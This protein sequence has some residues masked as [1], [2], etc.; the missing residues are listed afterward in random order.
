MR[1]HKLA[2]AGSGIVQMLI[3]VSVLALGG[4]A[5]IRLLTGA[6][7]ARAECA[8]RQIASLDG[9]AVRCGEGLD[10]APPPAPPGRTDSPPP[11]RASVAS[12]AR[13]READPARPRP[14]RAPVASPTDDRE[15]DPPGPPPA[16]APVAFL[17]GGREDDPE[18]G[19]GGGSGNASDFDAGDLINP[20]DV[21][22]PQPRDNCLVNG[23]IGPVVVG[24]PIVQPEL[25]PGGGP[26]V[27]CGEQ[28]PPEPEA[29]IPLIPELE[30]R[31]RA[32][33]PPAR[34]T[35]RVN[36]PCSGSNEC[37]R[38]H[39]RNVQGRNQCVDCSPS[40][41]DEVNAQIQSF[42]KGPPLSCRTLGPNPALA[43]I[44]E[45]IE[46]TTRCINART[47]RENRC[48]GG[49][50]KA[51]LFQISKVAAVRTLCRCLREALGN[52]DFSPDERAGRVRS[53]R[54]VRG[55]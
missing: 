28:R 19:E 21:L 52:P 8:G 49:G 14:D 26:R 34:G 35:K 30:S 53:C 1:R 40:A 43:L 2:E 9:A 33:A 13:D 15:A 4:L 20:T 12:P 50:D 31:N 55:I 22:R 23:G 39:C 7:A 36:E 3:L 54:E 10:L 42:C 51:H 47:R 41:F 37:A 25:V 46:G 11:D 5:A 29:P 48:F 45:R 6:V 27:S 38:G 17:G 24:G 18:G 16:P 44:D 32:T